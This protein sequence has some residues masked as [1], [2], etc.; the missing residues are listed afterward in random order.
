MSEET[1]DSSLLGLLGNYRENQPI[2]DDVV[3]E[4]S[5]DAS[6]S[7]EL[8][9][10]ED[11]VE[12]PTEDTEELSVDGS[13]EVVEDE[14][15]SDNTEDVKV[16]VVAEETNE[17]PKRKQRASKRIQTLVQEKKELEEQLSQLSG[18][19][20]EQQLEQLRVEFSGTVDKLK[21]Q[22]DFLTMQMKTML[23]QKEDEG[24]SDVDRAFKEHLT[25]HMSPYIET[26]EK[27]KVA[28]EQAMSDATAQ[29]KQVAEAQEYARKTE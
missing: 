29:A 9:P 19:R 24:L 15:Q 8:A 21:D 20:Q 14:V 12:P 28:R 7:A 3:E 25:R 1:K 6:V 22:N 11:V 5:L 4:G 13:E 18:Q 27:E 10:A 16:D 2:E 23:S 26:F 17:E